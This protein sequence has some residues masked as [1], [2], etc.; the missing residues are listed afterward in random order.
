MAGRK[1]FTALTAG[2]DRTRIEAKKS[3]LR[4]QLTLAEL[5]AARRMTQVRLAE[6]LHVRQPAVAKIEKRADMYVGN[7]RRYVA[8]MGGELRITASFPEGDIEIANFADLGEPAAEP[9]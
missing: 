6:V 9:A 7:L 3:V 4:Q 2:L 5:R 1:S 8:A